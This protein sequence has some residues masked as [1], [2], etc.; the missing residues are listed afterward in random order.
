MKH[1]NKDRPNLIAFTSTLS[2]PNHL[3]LV[4][5]DRELFYATIQ[6][7]G[8]K[9][10]VDHYACMV[11]SRLTRSTRAYKRSDRIDMRHENR[12]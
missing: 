8:L 7:H 4:H 10:K 1:L 5:K 2:S 3:D 11:D 9:P 6:D 12:A